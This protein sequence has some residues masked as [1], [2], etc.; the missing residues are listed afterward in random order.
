MSVDDMKLIA[1][2][3]TWNLGTLVLRMMVVFENTL[4]VST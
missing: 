4:E 1:R 3:N 2:S